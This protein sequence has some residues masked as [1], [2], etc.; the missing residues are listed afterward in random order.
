MVGVFEAQA[1]PRFRRLLEAVRIAASQAAPS[2]RADILTARGI[3][4]LVVENASAR[5][6][7]RLERL[8][9]ALVGDALYGCRWEGRDLVCELNLVALVLQ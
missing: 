2:R 6:A 4:Y 9:A 8:L 1:H 7:A 5:E 3:T